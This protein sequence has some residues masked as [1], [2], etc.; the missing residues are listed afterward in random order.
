[1]GTG[2]YCLTILSAK[3]VT[4][5]CPTSLQLGLYYAEMNDV[6]RATE[7]LSKAL[8]IDPDNVAATVHLA[9]LYL[10][11][12]SCDTWMSP[13]TVHSE[14]SKAT[15]PEMVAGFLDSFTRR[16]VGWDVPEAWYFLAKATGLQ[17]RKERQR[18][19]LAE[20]LRLEEGRPVRCLKVAL[21][22]SL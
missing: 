20:A 5:L 16:A 17:G 14:I 21:P 4:E 3:S 12:G 15:G 22:T 13:S 1:M 8:V 9:Q 10:L 6:A 18:E 7:S 11:P 19:C 2:V